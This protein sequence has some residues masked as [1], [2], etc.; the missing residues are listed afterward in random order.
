MTTA[1]T[2]LN[3]RDDNVSL[4]GKVARAAYAVAAFLFAI[5]LRESLDAATSGDKSESA[6]TWGL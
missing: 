1:T 5:E 6:I 3:Q 4:G 2:T